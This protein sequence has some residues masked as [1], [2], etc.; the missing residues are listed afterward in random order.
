[1]ILFET[2]LKPKKLIIWC[3][4][5]LKLHWQ[6]YFKLHGSTVLH[7]TGHLWLTKEIHI[8]KKSNIIHKIKYA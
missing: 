2:K 5:E 6:S 8:K 4:D 1:M 3:Y 7:C